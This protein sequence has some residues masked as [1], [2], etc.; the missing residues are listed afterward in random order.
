ME[1]N[2]ISAPMFY[3]GES[4][5]FRP[6]TRYYLEVLDLHD[7]TMDIGVHENPKS[8]IIKKISY[9]TLASFLKDWVLT[10]SGETSEDEVTIFYNKYK[11]YELMDAMSFMK[12]LFQD[13]KRKLFAQPI[14]SNKMN[15]SYRILRDLLIDKLRQNK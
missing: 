1:R 12:T 11:K 7:L 14:F 15:K 6:D 10:N 2:R 13:Y 4:S 5:D 8:E 9:T 3:I